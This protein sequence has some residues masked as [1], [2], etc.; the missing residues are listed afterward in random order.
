MTG[1]I[2]WEMLFRKT[3]VKPKNLTAL[4]IAPRNEKVRLEIEGDE[5]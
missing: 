5:E 2:N 1:Y 4:L 3:V